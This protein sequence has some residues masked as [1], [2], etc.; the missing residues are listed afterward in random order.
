MTSYLPTIDPRFKTLGD[1][2]RVHAARRPDHPALVFEERTTSW[3]AFDRQTNQVANVLLSTGL[4]PQSRIAYLGKNCDRFFDVYLG[5]AK[6]RMVLVPV[7]WRLAPEEIAFILKDAQAHILFIGVDYLPMVEALRSAVPGLQTVVSMDG[8]HPGCTEYTAWRDAGSVADP[9]LAA[10]SDEVALQLYTSGT[11]G[12]PKGA[13]L[14]HRG[15]LSALSYAAAGHLGRWNENDVCVVPLPLFHAG[16]VSYGMNAPY[17]GATLVLLREA[18]P[19]LIL[20]ALAEHRV[21]KLGLVPAVMQFMLDHPD[22][23][24]ADF[25]HLD[26][27]TYGGAPIP[28]ALLRRAVEVMGQVFLQMFGMTESTTLGTALKPRDHNPAMPERLAS[29]GQVLP[30][31]EMR[32]VTLQGRA[33]MPGESG[34]ILI[35]CPSIMKAYWMR[36]EATAQALKDGWYHTGDVGYFD[37]EGYLFIQDRLKDMIISGGENIY[38]AEVERALGDHPAIAESAVIGVP[39]AKWGEAVKAVVVVRPGQQLTEAEVIAFA[40]GKI[41]AYKCPK[42]VDFASA[43]PRNPSGKLL[44]RVLREPFW[45]GQERRVH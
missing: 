1:L 7:N 15:T 9:D 43:L 18:Q 21:T 13:E 41:A 34:E 36:P 45:A 31:V 4:A 39:D 2:C 19:A 29:C 6:A 30:G 24:K 44:K 22:C 38:P 3:A 35:R 20:Q 40:R 14:T 8:P 5:A 16:G 27:I 11:T 33:A 23:S 25:S 12:L 26:C 10:D 42:S 37:A 17:V 32:I 28:P